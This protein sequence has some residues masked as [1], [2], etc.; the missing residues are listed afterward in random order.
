M[1]KNMISMARQ[2]NES[3][4]DDLDLT[5]TDQV[6]KQQS[7]V[8]YK[9]IQNVLLGDVIQLKTGEHLGD[10]IGFIACM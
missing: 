6:P 3:S 1:H 5:S 7:V 2:N 4:T 9:D 8:R 10:F